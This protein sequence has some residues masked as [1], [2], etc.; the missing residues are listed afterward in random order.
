MNFVPLL[1][2]YN[3]IA[4]QA[5]GL[6]EVS[7]LDELRRAARALAHASQASQET[8]Q[9]A[10]AAG[11]PFVAIDVPDSAVEPV[12]VLWVEYGGRKLWPVNLFDI[13]ESDPAWRTRTASTPCRFVHETPD[14]ITLTPPPATAQPAVYLRV[15][16]QPT[17]TADKLDAELVRHYE[18]GLIDGAL[19]RILRMPGQT[20][21]NPGAAQQAQERYEMAISR[22][23]ADARRNHTLNNPLRTTIRP[24]A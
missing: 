18:E 20:W 17:R 4:P 10:V 11:N 3:A 23:R 9:V 8:L 16:Y 19:Y 15:A 5:P 12:G 1:D 13:M 6:N 22:A 7:A 24:L 21:T 2:L 14:E